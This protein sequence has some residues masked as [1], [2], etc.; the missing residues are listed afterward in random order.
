MRG[1]QERRPR[2]AALSAARPA[3]VARSQASGASNPLR[4]A[5]T[6]VTV[7]A[8]VVVDQLTKTWA[9]HH[10]PIAG[11]HVF[12]SLWFALTYNLGAA[13]GVGTGITPVLEVVAAGLVIVLFVTSRRISR[14]AGPV[15]LVGIGMVLG[16]ALSNLGDRIFRNHAGAVI[17]WIDALRVGN[18]DLWPVFNI[19]DV[20]IT[21]GA[22]VLVSTYVFHRS[23]PETAGEPGSAGGHDHSDE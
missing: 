16:G 7:V 17:D 8:L 20:G 2:L 19:A 15:G 13:F 6:G 21:V 14:G 12:G 1:L 18:H 4:A 9:L 10:A 3:E 11:R 5:V 22:I 23:L